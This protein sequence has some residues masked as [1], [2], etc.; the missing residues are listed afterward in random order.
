MHIY[1]KKIEVNLLHKQKELKESDFFVSYIS[2]FWTPELV[3]T[4]KH[5]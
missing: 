2:L 1:T 4:S 3:R 5:T